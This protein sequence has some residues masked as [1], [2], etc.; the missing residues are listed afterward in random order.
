MCPTPF[1]VD[2]VVAL[3][4]SGHPRVEKTVEL[5]D[6]KYWYLAYGIP[7]DRRNLSPDI[8]KIPGQ[9]HVCQSTKARRGKQPDTCEF[10]P[11][12]QYPFTSLAIDVCKLPN[13]LQKST[14]KRVD[15]LMVI[16]CH[17]T[18]YVLAIP[19]QEKGLDSKSA[20]SLFLNRFVHILGVP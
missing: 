17:Q 14:E 12:P 10:A 19:C 16:R 7:R 1:F 11:V 4:S 15:Y 6:T 5:F 2:V 8:A 20:A 3:H 13:C 18:G 9:C